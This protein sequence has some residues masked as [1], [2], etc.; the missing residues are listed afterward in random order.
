MQTSPSNEGGVNRLIEYAVFILVNIALAICF[1]SA[2]LHVIRQSIS[3]N[4]VPV[5]EASDSITW[6]ATAVPYLL[7]AVVLNFVFAIW[8]LYSALRWKSYLRLI[9]LILVFVLWIG[10]LLTFRNLHIQGYS[11]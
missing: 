4:G 9:L 7:Y 11:A 5:T 10:A 8:G 1:F 2:T 3:E 6:F